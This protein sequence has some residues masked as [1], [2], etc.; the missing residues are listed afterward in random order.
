MRERDDKFLQMLLFQV[1]SPSGLLNPDVQVSII[2]RGSLGLDYLT[3]LGEQHGFSVSNCDAFTSV[4]GSRAVLLPLILRVRKPVFSMFGC[5]RLLSGPE[6]ALTVLS[7]NV[8][9]GI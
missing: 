8:K 3:Q 1:K 5:P 7:Q 2:Y 6:L 9:S 4:V